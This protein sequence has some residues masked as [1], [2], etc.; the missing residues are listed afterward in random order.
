[1]GYARAMSSGGSRN[2]QGEL[3]SSGR[4]ARMCA[5]LADPRA[6]KL[7]LVAAAVVALPS[8]F[9]G[10]AVDD[11]WHRIYL[12]RPARWL[13]AVKP[14]LHLFTFYDGDAARS[15]WLLDQGITAWWADPKLRISFFRPV[16]AI[17][18]W[19]DYRLWPG[20]PLVMHA[21]SIAWYLVLVALVAA[22]YRRLVGAGWAAG[23]AA[24]LY[25]VDHTHGTPVGWLANRNVLVSGA[26]ALGSLWLYVRG[27]EGRRAA[28]WLSPLAF[29]VALLSGEAALGVAGYFV[30]HALFLD[31]ARWRKRALSLAPHALVGAGWAVV[32]RLGGYGVRGSGLYYDPLHASLEY[33]RRLPVN[34]SLLLSAELGA[35]SPDAYPLASPS[36][37]LVLVGLALGVLTLAAFALAP[38]VR[39]SA[40]ARFFLTGAVLATLPVCAVMPSART[41][42][43]PGF[44][45]VGL[46]ALVV[47][48]VV[49]R[50]A[51]LPSR[52][53]LRA[54]AVAVAVWAGG[55]H[56]LLSPLLFQVGAFQ[57]AFMQHVADRLATTFP[58]STSLP[59][60]RVVLVN[61]PDGAFSGY[62]LVTRWAHGKPVPASLLPLAV[63]T[64]AVDLSRTGPRTLL[65]R[66]AGGFLAGGTELLVRDPRDP[67]PVGTRVRAGG[68]TFQVVEATSDGRPALVRVTF[69]RKLEDPG[70]DWIVW[71]DQGFA[72]FTPPA[73][74][75]SVHIP[76]QSLLR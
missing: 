34:L 31:R 58:D 49:E 53:A 63:G 11:Y 69:D 26:F 16:S 67:M 62:L 57:M 5:L 27:R 71:T 44:G 18:H 29:A 30:A 41:L 61:A 66:S 3:S 50:S 7:A 2:E 6:A 70:L 65:V 48:A 33:V 24:L 32:Y 60:Q 59:Q 56:L 4:F 42:L 25:A 43:L 39:T 64:R 1:M 17:T 13:P 35:P 75:A 22:L 9:A 55:A 68:E 51:A 10:L 45:L 14:P 72:H 76:A 21:Q 8:L 12:T 46:V 54:P 74:G 73:V 20:A 47:H 37:Q 38:L 52:R 36:I 40:R 23:F 15:R 19:L 28:G